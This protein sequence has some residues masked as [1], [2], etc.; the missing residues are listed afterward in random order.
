MDAVDATVFGGHGFIGRH[1][2]AALS[3]EGLNVWVPERSDLADDLSAGIRERRLGHVVYAIGLTGDFRTRPADTVEAHAGLL[4]KLL[5]ATRWD[6]F[7]VMSS[8][9]IYSGATSTDEGATLAMRPNGDRLYD[10]SKM[11][12][13]ALVLAHPSPAARAVR[14]SNIFGPGMSET[15]FLGEVLAQARA[16]GKVTIGEAPTSAKDYLP[17]VAAAADCAA[18]ALR[19]TQRLYNVAS[20]TAVSHQTIATLLE[21]TLGTKVTFAPGGE[22]RRFEPVDIGRL[23]AEFPRPPRDIEAALKSFFANAG[24]PP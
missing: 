8:A 20:G 23:S 6:S 12:G 17:V 13:E 10:L 2:V 11:L 15:T 9:R 1:V 21:D 4:A 16:T 14:L 7:L 5:N 18:I 22:E 3:S 19:G 24:A